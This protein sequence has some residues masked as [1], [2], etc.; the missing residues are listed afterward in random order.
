MARVRGPLV[1][2]W[3]ALAAAPAALAGCRQDSG[4]PRHY[5]DPKAM[6]GEF[7]K[8]ER[9]AWSM[10]DRVV[11]SLAIEAKDAVIADIGAG[12]GY[13]T[14]RLAREAPAGKV[15]AV[16]ID[17]AFHKHI[18]QNREG[19]GT[20]NIE[21][22]LAFYDDP[23]LP[24]ASLDLVFMSNT[25]PYLRD[26]VAYLRRVRATLRPGGRLAL[27]SFHPDAKPPDASATDPKHRVSREQTIAEA[28]QAGFVL[29]REETFLPFQ[30][31]LIF[32]AAP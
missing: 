25:Y 10:P 8:E 30:F 3:V 28:E 1:A 7:E 18:E 4:P 2:L 29:D 11:R 27:I 12:S 5:D 6:I 31:F 20:P 13:F 19:W 23:A 32:K 26:R 21:P 9:D 15:Y 22:H 17:D 16:D 14:R 24:E